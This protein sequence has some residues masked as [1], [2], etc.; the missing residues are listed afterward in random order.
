MMIGT[1]LKRWHVEES[2]TREFQM[3]R[4]FKRD[5]AENDFEK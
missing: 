1:S 4:G 3:E 2:K 5:I